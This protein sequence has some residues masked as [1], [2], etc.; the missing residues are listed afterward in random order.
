MK[1]A[2]YARVS[3][4]DQ[5]TKNQV[6]ALLDY[7]QK[8]KD[9]DE[10]Y[11][12]YEETESAWQRGHQKQL[13]ELIADAQRGC[14]DTVLV[15]SLDRLTRGG[16]LKILEMIDLFKRHN[17]RV[18]SYQEPWTEAPGE[19]ADILYAITGWVAQMESQRRSERTKAGLERR[20]LEGKDIGRPTGSKDKKKRS[21][22][23]YRLRHAQNAVGKQKGV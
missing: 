2:I 8:R 18:I 19:I 20:R 1:L 13:K 9:I 15:W 12:V 4:E 10:L 5:T 17:I 6:H 21:N 11:H 22:A 7:C 3:T 23:G 14:F 16:A